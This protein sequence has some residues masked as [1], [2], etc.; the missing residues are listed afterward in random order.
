MSLKRK[1]RKK[2]GR[3]RK[4][5]NGSLGICRTSHHQ[6][7]KPEETGCT[8]VSRLANDDKISNA[9]NTCRRRKL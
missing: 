8:S 6:K 9:P 2:A 4:I 3:R 1:T 7:A 5:P